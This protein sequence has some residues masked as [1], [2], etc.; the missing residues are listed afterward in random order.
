EN[1]ELSV[2]SRVQELRRP[3]RQHSFPGDPEQAF[4]SAL[5]LA[6]ESLG[7]SQRR[8]FRHVGLLPGGPFTPEVLAAALGVPV[9]EALASLA[10]LHRAYLVEPLPGP[11]YRV[12]DLVK[13]L[14]RELGRHAEAGVREAR[15]RL[16][17]H[18]L[19]TAAD[20]AT[21]REWFEA[22]RRAL[23]SVVRTAEES[24]AYGVAWQLAAARYIGE[25]LADFATLGDR[26]GHARALI[27]LAEVH[28]IAGNLQDALKAAGEA[29]DGYREIGDQAGVADSL[30][31]LS[32]LYLSQ[33]R[34]E[35]ALDHAGKALEVREKLGDRRGTAQ[36]LIMMARV[37]QSLGEPDAAVSEGLGALSICHELGDE[38]AEA[39]TL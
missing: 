15:V 9:R 38:H 29:L 33:G 13:D 23:V 8:A 36:S 2:A 18:Y 1:P 25:A 16:L 26:A 7:P 24:G 20:P 28:G 39:E 34:H 27:D 3:D 11:R 17:D 37:R 35:L 19:V 5:D 31:A 4:R 21:P 12:H 6:Y 14:A 22:E 10:G 30:H 32:R